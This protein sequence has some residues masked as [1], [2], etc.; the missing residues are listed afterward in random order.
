MIYED[1]MLWVYTHVFGR[2]EGGFVMYGS[3]L[4]I[5]GLSLTEPISLHNI[6]SAVSETGLHTK[7]T[8]WQRQVSED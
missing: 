4:T 1:M 6:E 3:F 7:R 2:S 8:Y 5:D